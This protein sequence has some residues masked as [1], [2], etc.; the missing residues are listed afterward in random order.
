MRE[1]KFELK[2]VLNRST[3]FRIKKRNKGAAFIRS[4]INETLETLGVDL[5]SY[6]PDYMKEL[7]FYFGLVTYPKDIIRYKT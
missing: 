6:S 1:F 2:N 7:V 4:S 5:S 3:N